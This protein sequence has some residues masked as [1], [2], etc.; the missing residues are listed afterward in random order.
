MQLCVAAMDDLFS[1]H[2]A[3]Q[4]KA[5]ASASGS[6][7]NYLTEEDSRQH[8]PARDEWLTGWA[9]TY[10]KQL[11]CVAGK[12]GDGTGYTEDRTI[13][14]LGENRRADIQRFDPDMIAGRNRVYI[15]LG[16]ALPENK[17]LR[18]EV[19]R[20]WFTDGA[21]GDP[22]QK[23]TRRQFLK[24]VDAGLVDNIYDD[25]ALDE[26]RAEWEN[27]QLKTGNP[28]APRPEDDAETHLRTHGHYMKSDEF[29][30][31]PTEVQDL[32]YAHAQ[33]HGMTLAPAMPVDPN[34]QP[35]QP[36]LPGPDSSPAVG[37]PVDMLKSVSQGGQEPPAPGPPGQEQPLE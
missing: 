7:I 12:C 3:S 22:T 25:E 32:F 16:G 17:V 4:G 31:L 13:T 2:L 18:A 11:D 30:Q 10:E 35:G 24:L 8:G 1:D 29:L 14:V 27:D 19:A 21:L 33:V 6:A 9:R 15:A 28:L 5:P 23:E 36:P 37:N 34:A 26:I 20:R